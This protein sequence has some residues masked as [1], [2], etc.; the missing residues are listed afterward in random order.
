MRAIAAKL[1]TAFL[2]A[3]FAGALIAPGV[4]ADEGWTITSVHANI[5]LSADSRLTIQ[6]DTRVDFGSQQKHGIFRTIPTRYRYDD[7][8]DRYYDVTV[9][10][11]TDGAQPVM[12]TTS[13]DNYNEVIKIGDPNVLVSGRQRYVISYTVA[14]AMN[15]FA[16]HDELFW[17]VDGALW[18]VPK[19]SVVATV[20][21]PAGSFQRA[22]CYQGPNGSLETC[23]FTHTTSLA[24]YN[25]TRQLASGEQMSIVTALDKGAITVPPPLLE[26]R[27]R[28]FPQDA[29]SI[30]P[31]TVATGPT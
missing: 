20:K 10:S 25:S 18:P 27:L 23:P 12:Y 28:Q 17:N 15:S 24:T 13:V 31:L 30:N 8:H 26:P 22:A 29:F 3:A 2:A 4:H 1:A 7:T 21:F 5:A 6:E 19:Q 9:N 16:D 14:G 11:V